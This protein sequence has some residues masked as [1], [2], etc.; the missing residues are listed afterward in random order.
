MTWGAQRRPQTG[1][2]KARGGSGCLHTAEAVGA[3]F[4]VSP[5]P[6]GVIHPSHAL[7]L[8][9]RCSRAFTRRWILR[10]SVPGCLAVM[11]VPATPRSTAA[12]RHSRAG[13]P[14]TR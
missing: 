11:D 9:G 8:P 6:C 4:V 10:R 1:G 13:R 12:V 7:S 2:V 14:R 5:A 3:I